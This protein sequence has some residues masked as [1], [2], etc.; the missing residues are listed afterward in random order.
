MAWGAGDAHTAGVERGEQDAGLGAQGSFEDAQS[1]G[2]GDAGSGAGG[3]QAAFG[4]GG[5]DFQLQ[6]GELLIE[7]Q[8]AGYG[9]AYHAEGAP[10][11]GQGWLNF[12]IF[13][14]DYGLRCRG[15]PGR[16]L[17][18][19]EWFRFGRLGRSRGLGGWGF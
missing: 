19:E 8:D 7:L 4:D 9:L 3:D 12:G 13:R 15:V 11:F 5:V 2:A 16:G 1:L 17:R 6:S 18:V 14:F 10:R